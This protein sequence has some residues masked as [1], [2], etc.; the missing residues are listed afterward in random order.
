[1]NSIVKLLDDC[2]QQSE[3]L[4]G[5]KKDERLK[6]L[7]GINAIENFSS[8][9]SATRIEQSEIH[10]MRVLESFLDKYKSNNNSKFNLS[11]ISEEG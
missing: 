9:K 11:I 7:F 1:M 6:A 3:N 2:I 5:L 10:L 8:E 4:N